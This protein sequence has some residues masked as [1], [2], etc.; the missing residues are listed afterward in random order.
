MR[1]LILTEWMISVQA[2]LSLGQVLETLRQDSGLTLNDVSRTSGIPLTSV[3]RLFHDQVAKPN[4]AHLTQL[5]RVL[6]VHP[7][8]VLNAAGYPVPGG[9]EDLD[10]ALRAA[11]TVPEE[12]IAE[13]RAA[14]EAVAARYADTTGTGAAK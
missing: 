9:T 1:T 5:A 4:P 3:H 11:Y 13:M 7:R 2:R 10:A 8:V 12:A 14:I 6:Q